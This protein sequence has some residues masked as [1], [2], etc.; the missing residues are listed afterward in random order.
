MKKLL[1]VTVIAMALLVTAS[2]ALANGGP[3][4]GY[5]ATTDACAGCH[6]AHTASGPNLLVETSTYALCMT[7]HGSTAAG[8][9]T[10]VEDGVYAQYNDAGTYTNKTTTGTDGTVGA[11]LNGGGFAYAYDPVDT[12]FEAV[13]AK[14]DSQGTTAAA[15]GNGVARGVTAALA[16]NLTCGSCHDPHGTD[17]YR[18]LR[19]GPTLAADDYDSAGKDYTAEAWGNTKMS[20]FCANCHGAYH[21]TRADSGTDNSDDSGG[22]TDYGGDI[23]SYAHR[24]DMSYVYN[25]NNNPE[26][27]GTYNL[28]LADSG[29]S[30]AVVCSTCHLSHGSAAAMSGEADN[31]GLAGGT[32]T[33]DNALLRLD[34]RGVCE[35]CHQK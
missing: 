28:P 6:R 8:A 27:T 29:T 5:T 18:L 1:W 34:N 22:N 15:W 16:D 9:Q 30:D 20:A 35:A 33:T 14:H 23:T 3:H 21:V 12:T 31:G 13:I 7:C 24:V 26:T 32:S 19:W 2:L 10:N 4:G 25:G 11:A 17:G